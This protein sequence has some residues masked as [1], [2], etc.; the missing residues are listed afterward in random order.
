MLDH[1][2]ENVLIIDN[3]VSRS[4]LSIFGLTAAKLAK[5]ILDRFGKKDVVAVTTSRFHDF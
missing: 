5:G 2:L 4:F 1:E 3:L